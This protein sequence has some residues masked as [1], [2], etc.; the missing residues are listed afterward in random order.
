[1]ET[2]DLHSESV[3][4][5]THSSFEQ[6]WDQNGENRPENAGLAQNK[7]TGQFVKGWAGGPGR[8]KTASITAAYKE[9][10]ER[11]GADKM[12]EVIYNDALAARNARD[13]LAAASEITDR[14]E[15]KA[16]QRVDMRG[17]VVMMPATAELEALDS[18]AGDDE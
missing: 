10:L 5:L 18:W 11:D 15:G 13:R 6:K 4:K 9:I 14:V 8:P 7:N 2:Q 17:I 16:T 1:M 3:S 12:A